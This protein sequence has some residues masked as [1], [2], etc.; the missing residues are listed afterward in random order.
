MQHICIS[1]QKNNQWKKKFAYFSAILRSIWSQLPGFCPINY[2]SAGSESVVGQTF[3]AR[4]VLLDGFSFFFPKPGNTEIIICLQ[5]LLH[6]K[7][8]CVN[9]ACI[10]NSL[11]TLIS[12]DVKVL[13]WFLFFKVCNLKVQYVICHIHIHICIFP[14]QLV[15]GME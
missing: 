8:F 1:I 6:Y 11:A 3:L 2:F 5:C 10:S 12:T 13:A 15:S 7:I 4:T 14:D 9:D